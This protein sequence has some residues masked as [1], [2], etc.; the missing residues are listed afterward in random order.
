M[1]PDDL[2]DEAALVAAVQRGDATAF[3]RLVRRHLPRAQGVALRILRH[4]QDAEDLV[5][6]AFLRALDRIDQCGPGRPF[7]PWFFRLLTTQALNAR[8]NR[9]RR[10]TD[11]VPDD[12]A[13]SAPGADDAVVA[14]DTATRVRAALAQLPERQRAAVELVELEGFTS[15]D[16]AAVLG[17]PAGTIRWHLH[18]ARRALRALLADLAPTPQGEGGPA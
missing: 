2:T 15:A 7:A 10:A 14:R 11:E 13:G 3:D 4:R 5:H 9:A 17:I 8:R 18:E 6:D 16:A 12:V 1:T